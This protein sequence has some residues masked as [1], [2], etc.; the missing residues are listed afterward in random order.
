M[1]FIRTAAIAM[2]LAA[3]SSAKAFIG[4]MM[5]VTGPTQIVRGKEKIE[6]KVEVGVEMNDSVETLKSRVSITFE[7]NTKMQVTEFSKLSRHYA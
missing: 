3:A 5:E 4:K 2:A 7:D 6:G 1:Q